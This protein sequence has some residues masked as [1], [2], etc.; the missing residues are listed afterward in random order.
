MSEPCFSWGTPVPVCSY[1]MLC[2]ISQGNSQSRLS[3]AGG[4]E[5][6]GR[7]LLPKA[8]RAIVSHSVLE[9]VNEATKC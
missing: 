3:P 8:L 2:F 9:L 5:S 1:D 7:I 6:G 4:R